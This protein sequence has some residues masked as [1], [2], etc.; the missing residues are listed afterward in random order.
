MMVLELAQDLE[1]FHRNC[2]W[3]ASKKE[4]L[5]QVPWKKFLQKY[6]LAPC[7]KPSKRG[8]YYEP[9]ILEIVQGKKNYTK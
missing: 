6:F 9:N 1:I 5:F 7:E 2:C 3:L 8:L 4:I